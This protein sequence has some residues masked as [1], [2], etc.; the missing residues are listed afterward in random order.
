MFERPA[1]ISAAYGGGRQVGVGGYQPTEEERN[2]AA[3]ATKAKLDAFR[4]AAGEPL[5][6]SFVVMAA[7]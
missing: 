5:S 4:K 1:D 3:A 2:A 7:L 6:L